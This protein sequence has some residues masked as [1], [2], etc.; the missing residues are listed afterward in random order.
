MTDIKTIKNKFNHI[1]WSAERKY[2]Q[3]ILI[4]YKTNVKKSWQIIKSIINTRKFMLHFT[5]F[6]N[7]DSSIEN[8]KL[9]ADKFNKFFFFQY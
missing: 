6:R 1:L 2:H 7:N 9:V 4:E 3:A 8:G 5:S